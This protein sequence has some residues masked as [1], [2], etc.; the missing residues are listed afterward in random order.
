MSRIQVTSIR[1]KKILE[2]HER[3]LGLQG[4]IAVTFGDRPVCCIKSDI[5]IHKVI[6]RKISRRNLPNVLSK[7]K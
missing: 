6:E 5:V 4:V 3:Q 7:K 1:Y 2:T